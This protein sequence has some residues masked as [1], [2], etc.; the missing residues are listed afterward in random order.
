MSETRVTPMPSTRTR[1]AVLIGFAAS[2]AT[3]ILSACGG[4]SKPT[5]TP[6]PA[7][8]LASIVANLASRAP[9]IPTANTGAGSGSTRP[10]SSNGNVDPGQVLFNP[11]GDLLI[12]TEKATNKLDAY[13]VGNDGLATQLKVYDAPDKTPFALAFGRNNVLL[14]ADAAGD[15]PGQGTVSSYV[16]RTRTICASSL[17]RRRR[18]RPRPAGW[19]L[20]ATGNTPTPGTPGTG[21]SP[22]TRLTTPDGLIFSARTAKPPPRAREHATSPSVPA[23][24]IAMC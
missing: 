2:V 9:G 12:V 3:A 20:R 14:S 16:V 18:G 22:A 11:R 17:A 24:A 1:R 6:A 13:A 19:R 15:A 10:L 23:A 5:D 21:S 4:G 7:N 8:G